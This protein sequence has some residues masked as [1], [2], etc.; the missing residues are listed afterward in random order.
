MVLDLRKASNPDLL[1][2]LSVLSRNIYEEGGIRAVRIARISQN[3]R[4]NQFNI[5]GGVN[6]A[7]EV[8]GNQEKG[9]LCIQ[10]KNK[11][12]KQKR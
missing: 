6:Y 12:A 5:L 2:H 7:G 1:S 8:G 10:T 4:R 3:V 11:R 9:L